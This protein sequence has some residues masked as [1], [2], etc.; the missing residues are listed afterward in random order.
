TRVKAD[1]KVYLAFVARL[2]KNRSDRKKDQ[3]SNFSALNHYA[4][5]GSSP[6]NNPTL[7]QNSVDE[8]QL[9]SIRGSDLVSLVQKYFRT[10]K[11]TYAYVGPD[12]P[13]TVRKLIASVF[14]AGRSVGKVQIAENRNFALQKTD[15]SMVYLL[16]YDSRQFRFG[17]RARKGVFSLKKLPYILLFNEYFGT[18]GLDCIVFREIRESRSLAYSAYAYYNPVMEKGKFEAFVG[19]AGT[20]KD[21]FFEAAEAMMALF[22]KVPAEEKQFRQAKKKLITQLSS[23]RR[24][25]LLTDFYFGM[26]KMGI[27]ED[28]CRDL[29][30]TLKKLTL[31]DILSFAAENVSSGSYDFFILGPVREL[32]HKKLSRYG[33]VRLLSREEVFG[34]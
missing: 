9:R 12:S 4:A 26:E 11:R 18:G 1:E 34:Y 22:R 33:T 2:L 7:Y 27:R 14:P 17:I 23:Q 21:K 10:L 6:E 15:R 25:G 30:E 29:L 3:N 31:K 8:K 20:Q 16:P 13:Q 5:Y 28:H 32:D 19:V 24:Y